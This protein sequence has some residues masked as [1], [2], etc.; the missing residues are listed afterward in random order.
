MWKLRIS[1]SLLFVACFLLACE[2][3]SQTKH[4]QP[5]ILFILVD[6]LGY[7]DLACYGSEEVISP[8]IDLLAKNGIKCTSAY[9][10]APQCAPS[11]AGLITGFYQQKYG[12]EVNPEPY[13]RD[14]FGLDTSLLTM[15]DH[16]K[17]AGYATY[18]YGKWDLGAIPSAQPW[19]R[20][21]DSFYGFYTGSRNYFIGNQ[22]SE[23]EALRTGPNQRVADKGYITDLISNEAI[24]TINQKHN[25]PWFMYVSYSCPHWPMQAKSLDL[26]KFRHIKD[27]QRRTYL[28]MM[29]N[30]DQNIGNLIQALK[31]TKQ[32]KNTLIVFLSDNGGPTGVARASY[33]APFE[34][35]TN[36]S[37]N[38][39][40]KG[41][42]GDVFEGGIRVPCIFSW[43]GVL[44][45]N[46]SY[47]YP[48]SSLDLAPTFLNLSQPDKLPWF[49]GIDVFPSLKTGQKL[50]RQAP[51]FWRWKEKWAIRYKDWKLVIPRRGTEQL[52]QITVDPSEINNLAKTHPAKV[53]ELKARLVKWDST[54]QVPKYINFEKVKKLAAPLGAY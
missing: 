46:T 25:K 30:L 21:F 48:I 5:N 26:Q 22:E 34:K 9:V 45:S 20:G 35:G 39:P 28:A 4:S 17:S 12:F 42:K 50:K 47:D 49:E 53:K 40:F 24:K 6:D 13:F 32:D 11:R 3:P 19:N 14:K 16:L 54:L 1:L 33:N 43:P 31:Q 52:Y 51:L 15:A 37:L 44:A 29:Y 36:T 7:A 8:N 10:T 27:V 41:V 23:Y 38:L 18:G 2:E